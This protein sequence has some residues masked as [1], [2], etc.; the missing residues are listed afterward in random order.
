MD[1]YQEKEQSFHFN[2]YRRLPVTMVRGEGSKVWDSNG[3]EYID[4][5]AGIAVN[6]VGHCHP[7]VVKA[8][9]EQAGE[10]LH[11]TNIYYNKPQAEL[12]ELLVNQSEFDRVFFCNSGLEANEAAIKLVRKYAHLNNRQGNIISFLGSFHGRSIASITMGGDKLQKGFGPLPEGFQ[13]LP[14]NDRA[15]LEENLDENAI[16]VFVEAVQGEGG[17]VPATKEFMS[18]LGELCK[19]FDVLLVVDEIQTGFGRT[20]KMFGYQ[21]Y[22][23]QPDMIT[24][25]KAMGGGVPIGGILAS[26]QLASSFEFG[27]HGTTFGGNPL[28][29]AASYAAV[30]AIITEGL[31]KRS[32]EMG[33]YL[34]DRLKQ[35]HKLEKVV[36]IRGLGL[37]AGIELSVPCR[38]IVMDMLNRGF[39]INCTADKTIRLVPPLTIS[40]AEIDLLLENLIDS[41]GQHGAI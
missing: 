38:P 35:L 39:L 16:A 10:L 41:I 33:I 14:F 4:F 21:H 1:K 34:L 30:S 37:M 15:A 2:L 9:R 3:K 24:I 28:A 8:I 11:I 25:A 18:K 36:D 31:V 26:E 17:V 12:S 29:C 19:K 13:R 6:S 7:Q 27:D 40:R 22:D 20:G 32:E 5:L 23:I